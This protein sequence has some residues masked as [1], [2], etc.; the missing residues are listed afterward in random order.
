MP[1]NAYV[2]KEEKC[3]IDNLSSYLKDLGKEGQNITKS[4]RRK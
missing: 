3:Q 4:S 1:L 2:T